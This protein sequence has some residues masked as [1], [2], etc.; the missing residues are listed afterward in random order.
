MAPQALNDQCVAIIED[1][2]DMMEQINREIQPYFR[3]RCF[4]NGQ[5]A[6]DGMAEQT[7]SLVLCDIMLPDMTGYDIVRKMRKSNATA[8]TPVI[9]LTALDD[10]SHQIKGYQAGADD[11]MVKP[12]NFH[13]LIARMISLIK[14][15]QERDKQAE[16]AVHAATQDAAQPA[17]PSA[18]IL[19]TRAD[20]YFRQQLEAIVGKHI[21]DPSLNVDKLAELMHIGRTRFY[22]KVKEIFGISPNKYIANRRLETA[23]SL[24]IEGQYN[25]TEVAYKVGF[26]DP[27]YFYKCFKQKY[28]VMPSKYKG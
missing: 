13:I 24:L 27:A 28:G 6:I 15:K 8:T 16:Q 5:S 25:V 19:E 9:M 3:T 26:T 7:P 11:Y 10:E 14:W 21:D 12:C 4:S 2:P 1:D 18:Q 20:L 23:A 17:A 22:G